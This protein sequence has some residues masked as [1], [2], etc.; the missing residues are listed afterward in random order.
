[1]T[2]GSSAQLWDHWNFQPVTG[3]MPGVDDGL[4]ARPLLTL[5]ERGTRM[6]RSTFFAFFGDKALALQQCCEA[7]VAVARPF[8]CEV[9]ETLKQG[10]VRIGEGAAGGVA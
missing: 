5:H 7:S 1:M 10:V 6:R 2:G 4:D 8:E 3:E 9:Y